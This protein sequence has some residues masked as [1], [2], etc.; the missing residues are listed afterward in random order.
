MMI[1]RLLRAL[2]ALGCVALL[3]GCLRPLHAPVSGA[4]GEGN[5]ALGLIDVAPMNGFLGHSI[6]SELDFLLQGGNP[7]SIAPR[8]RFTIQTR[9]TKSATTLDTTTG[10][11]QSANLEIEAVYSLI[12]MSDGVLRA[13]GRTYVSASYDRSQ[14]RFSSLRAERDAEERA[15]RA[16]A[17]RLRSIAAIALSNPNSRAESAPALS[18]QTDSQKNTL[19]PSIG[20]ID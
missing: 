18:K 3:T 15:A 17:E 7:P 16:L 14:L 19:I 9:K 5:G 1:P 4:D 6:K 20:S 11:A 13:S 12:Q 8:Y 2:W 10:L